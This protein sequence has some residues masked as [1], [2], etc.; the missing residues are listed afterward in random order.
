MTWNWALLRHRFCSIR[1]YKWEL[2][3]CLHGVCGLLPRTT[4]QWS[5]SPS[6]FIA[7]LL[8][9][10]TFSPQKR[11]NCQLPCKPNRNEYPE[12]C[13]SFPSSAETTQ[14]FLDSQ[15]S[16]LQFPGRPGY[17]SLLSPER[18]TVPSSRSN[19]RAFTKSAKEIFQVSSVS[20]QT[21]ALGHQPN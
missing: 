2:H 1:S 17:G 8:H 19:R 21:Q 10:Y 14:I 6:Y 12:V 3:V 7:M 4:L 15:L 11:D 18:V 20:Q 13:E 16:S 9:K 5:T